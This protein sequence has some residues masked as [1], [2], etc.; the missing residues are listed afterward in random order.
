MNK[1]LERYGWE[2]ILVSFKYYKDTNG[3]RHYEIF[4]VYN[5]IENH[6]VGIISKHNREGIKINKNYLDLVDELLDGQELFMKVYDK[7][8]ND[9]DNICKHNN[10]ITNNCSDCDDNELYDL[11]L[12]PVLNAIKDDYVGGS[13]NNLTDLIYSIHE[14]E[15]DLTDE[16]VEKMEQ[17]ILKR[18]TL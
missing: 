10:T 5:E 1:E 6:I 7:K 15:V 12:K 11:L 4:G 17:D 2:N 14:G 13:Y 16:I 3:E 18:L 8:K 9:I